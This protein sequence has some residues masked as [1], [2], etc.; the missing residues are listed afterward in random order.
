M[1]LSYVEKHLKTEEKH[2]LKANNGPFFS[3]IEADGRLYTVCCCLCHT[4]VEPRLLFLV[5]NM[6]TF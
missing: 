2:I 4:K 5:L 1:L 3:K 6:A